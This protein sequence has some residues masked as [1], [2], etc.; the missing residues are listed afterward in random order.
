MW[1]DVLLL[2]SVSGR[3]FNCTTGCNHW[4]IHINWTPVLRS[5]VYD[6]VQ[7]TF[8]PESYPAQFVLTLQ[9]I[10]NLRFHNLFDISSKPHQFISLIENW[11]HNRCPKRHLIM[12]KTFVH[13]F[14]TLFTFL[15][16]S[17]FSRFHTIF[18]LKSPKLFLVKN[19]TF[20]FSGK[21]IKPSFICHLSTLVIPSFILWAMY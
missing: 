2:S 9:L 20:D 3:Y 14:T 8:E 15:Q 11:H 7:F 10:H 13:L 17:P 18:E 1:A 12:F 16:L 6:K 5:A 19:I 21:N 4:S